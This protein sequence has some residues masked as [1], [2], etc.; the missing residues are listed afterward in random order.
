MTDKEIYKRIDFLREVL[1]YSL[2]HN[3]TLTSGE[4]ICLHQECGAWLKVL[5]I[6]EQEDPEDM[7][8][9][10]YVIPDDLRAKTEFISQKIKD[11]KWKKV[12]WM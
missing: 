1:A 3:G 8:Q 6:L 5:Y 12:K 7:P 10:F 9:P 2:A 4:R 11:T